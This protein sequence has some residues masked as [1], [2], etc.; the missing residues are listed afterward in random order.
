MSD[1]GITVNSPL[2]DVKRKLWSPPS[3]P[4]FLPSLLLFFFP[5]F[6]E[7]VCG[8]LS[9]T[10]LEL[11]GGRQRHIQDTGGSGGCPVLPGPRPISQL[12]EKSVRIF[13]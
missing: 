8:Q 6:M 7:C 5:V 10:L 1:A 12:H 11:R 9:P 4:A 2:E 13:R 3:Q